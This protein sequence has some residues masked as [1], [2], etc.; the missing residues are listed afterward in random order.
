VIPARTHQPAPSS[1]RLAAE[2]AVVAWLATVPEGIW[3]SAQL[4]D[5]YH[6]DPTRPPLSGPHL[7]LILADLGYRGRRTTQA[8]YW[9]I[10]TLATDQAKLADL[11]AAGP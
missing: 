3:T 11:G 7:G 6:S 8:R 4:R 5:W 1:S 2:P 10:T 9:E